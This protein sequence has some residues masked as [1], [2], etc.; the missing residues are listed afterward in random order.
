MA[1]ELNLKSVAFHQPVTDIQKEYLHSSMLLL[2]S[3]SEGFGMVLIEA[4]ACGVPCISFDCPSGPRDI[5]NNGIDGILVENQ[6][7]EH[8]ENAIIHL[9]EK[10]E[11][12]WD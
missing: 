4:M 8:F 1:K 10:R 2:P 7:L 9:I 3:R 5:I 11:Q 12:R 6:N